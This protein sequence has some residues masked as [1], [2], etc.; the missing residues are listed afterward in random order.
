MTSLTQVAT[1]RLG[2]RRGHAHPVWA[3]AGVP[4]TIAPSWPFGVALTVWTVADAL[5]PDAV[6]DRSAVAYV[7][8]AVATAAALVLTLALHEAAHCAAACR[9][10]LGVRRITL[11]F[12]GGALELAEAPA[13]P[14]AELRVALAGPLASAAAAAVATVAHV[15]FVFADVDPLLAAGAAVVAVGNLLVATF[16]CLPALPLDGGRALRAVLWALTG[17]E[18]TGA[19]LAGVAGQALS[20]MLFVLAVVASASADAALAIWLGLLGLG[21]YMGGPD[22]V[23]ET[24]QRFITGL[25][26]R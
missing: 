20:V 13:T 18:A 4:V 6:P 5:L 23:A 17:R 7:A 9:A 12:L 25:P 24:S 15:A 10:G 8:T 11:S 21:V 14:A 3:P 1:L 19:R 26:R 16:N 2:R 22:L